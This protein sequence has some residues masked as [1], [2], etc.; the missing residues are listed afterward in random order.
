MGVQ[1]SSIIP[2]KEI[3]LNSLS[4]KKIAIDAYNTFFQFLSIIRDRDTGE[5]LRNSKGEIT[6]HISGI[7]Y[8]SLK[9]MENG[10]K[11][12]YVID[13][14][15]PDLKRKT[16]KERRE[17]REEAKEKWKKAVEEGRKEDIMV[18]AQSALRV[19]DEMVETGK[20]LL[21]AMG[22]PWVQAP[23]E[24]EAQA[25]LIV[26][27]GDA[28]SVG[29]Q[30]MD[31]VMFGSKRL[32]RNLSSTGKKKLP[33]QEVWV[34]VKPELIELEKV[35]SE[36]GLDKEKLIWMGMLMKFSRVV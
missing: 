9:H 19:D 25:T 16:T 35:Y 26:N 8:R 3:E 36:L 13:G 11:P 5:P 27:N 29:S 32:V 23:S 6:S 18:Y 15:P 34:E 33:R 17:A 20:E 2:K 1:I 12:I 10:I 22:I 28:Y 4:G 14:K 30:D 21:D 31:A 24:G 7:F